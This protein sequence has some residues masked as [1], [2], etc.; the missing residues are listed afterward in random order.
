MT[1]KR[2]TAR[3]GW[4]VGFVRFRWLSHATHIDFEFSTN[5]Q[6][7]LRTRTTTRNKQPSEGYSHCISPSNLSQCP[8]THRS[9]FS[10]LSRG[11]NPGIPWVRTYS[12]VLDVEG[13]TGEEEEVCVDVDVEAKSEEVEVDVDGSSVTDGEED[14]EASAAG[15]VA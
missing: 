7:A 10:K 1:R 12:A 11:K 3:T 8:P 2:K 15:A 4:P 13:M 6:N 5:S 14:E 9:T